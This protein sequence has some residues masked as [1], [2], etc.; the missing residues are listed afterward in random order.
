MDLKLTVRYRA[1]TAII[2]CVGRLV[3]GEEAT[4]LRARVK[5]LIAQGA[6]SI[7]LDLAGVR[8]I[9]S[10]ALG[11]LTGL[12]MSARQA[13]CHFRLAN[14]TPRTNK[15]LQT[16][17]LTNFFDIEASTSVPRSA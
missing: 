4:S 6:K 9:D 14:L 1:D 17:N 7:T 12:H 5:G 8:Y 10:G 11:V 3:Y 16:T 15:L 13:N 2:A